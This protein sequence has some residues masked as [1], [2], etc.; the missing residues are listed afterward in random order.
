MY[1]F[2]GAM[3]SGL[4]SSRTEASPDIAGKRDPLRS[5]RVTYYRQNPSALFMEHGTY[6][7]LFGGE[8][9]WDPEGSW[10]AS[11]D[12]VRGGKSQSHLASGSNPKLVVY[13]G[14][15]DITALGGAGFASR[16]SVDP[17]SW[18]LAD[19][20]GL[21]IGVQQGDAKKYTITLKDQILPRRPRE[22][23]TVSWEYDFE[24]Q[25]SEV[26]IPWHEFKPTYRGKPKPD[27]EPVDLR[28]VKRISIMCRSFFGEQ[29]G[30]FRLELHHIAAVTSESIPQLPLSNS[31]TE[32]PGPHLKVKEDRS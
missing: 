2:N 14:N 9:P 1:L 30:A 32:S 31:R 17:L 18:D 26:V 22:Q 15:L 10:I 3:V 24:G 19:Y 16:R 21:S 25:A 11:D 6:Y 4:A 28:N 5:L 12:R 7:Y 23:S 20:Q 29:E 13:H 8:K 27:A